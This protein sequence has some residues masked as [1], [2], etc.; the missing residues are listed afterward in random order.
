MNLFD[1]YIDWVDVN[2]LNI[3]VKKTK[4]MNLCPR[5]KNQ[6]IDKSLTVSKEQDCIGNTLGYIYL[7]VN[8][9]QNLEFGDFLQE[10]ES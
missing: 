5:N 7:G 10:N 9:D 2:C 8:V 3:N 4:Q 6:L 1:K